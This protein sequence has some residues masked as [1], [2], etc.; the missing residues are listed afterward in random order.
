MRHKLAHDGVCRL[1]GLLAASECARI[2]N[3][4]TELARFERSIDMLP[5]G[6]GF[7]SYYYYREPLPAPADTLREILYNE[8]APAGYPEKLSVFWKRCRAAGQKTGVIH[9]DWVRQ[10]RY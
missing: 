7:G 5:R 8:L 3:D 4:S 9:L 10:G 2:L 1:E 6:Y